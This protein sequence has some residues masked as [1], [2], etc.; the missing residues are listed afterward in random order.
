MV[1]EQMINMPSSEAETL[2]NSGA[3]KKWQEDL[4]NRLQISKSS[5]EGFEVEIQEDTEKGNFL[6]KVIH[7][8]HGVSRD[9]LF[10]P[11]FFAT[12]DYAHMQKLGSKLEGLLEEGAYVRRGEKQM[13]VETFKEA[14]EW[15]MKEAK[16]GQKIQRYKIYLS[17]SQTRLGLPMKGQSTCQV[18]GY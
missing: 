1:V 15:L 9:Y 18:N 14:R 10:N 7:M 11:D 12:K 3:M 16:K 5:A 13:P 17:T 2:Q 4:N 8:Q 6:P